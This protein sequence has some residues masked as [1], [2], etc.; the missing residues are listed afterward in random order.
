MQPV[1]LSDSKGS[2]FSVLQ[3]TKLSQLAVMTL[4]P[5]QDSGQGDMH[6]GDQVVYIIE[7]EAEVEIEDTQHRLSA[8]MAVII[9]K[10]STHRI[11]NRGDQ[12]VFFL[13]VYAPPAY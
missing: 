6:P 4:A 3:Q 5:G 10:D 12:D 1:I 11:Y 2:F 8:G 9:P 13:N 7:G